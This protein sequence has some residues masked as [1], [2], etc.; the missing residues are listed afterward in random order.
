MGMS[1]YCTSY[2][3]KGHDTFTGMPVEHECIRI[4]PEALSMEMRGCILT[5]VS[6]IERMPDSAKRLHR[7]RA[8]SCE[9]DFLI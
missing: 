4:P 6:I 2:C 5:A 7:G 3:N 8:K 1:I 9:V